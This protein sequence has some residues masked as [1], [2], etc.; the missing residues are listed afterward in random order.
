MTD[1][2]KECCG[3]GEVKPRTP[4]HFHFCNGY[5][6][7]RCKSCWREWE[8]EYFWANR[9]KKRAAKKRQWANSDKAAEVRRA[10]EWK[11]AN[12]DKVRASDFRRNQRIRTS[13]E[14][15]SKA[16]CRVRKWAQANPEATAAQRARRRARE[17]SAEGEYSR[18]DV[19]AILHLQEHKCFYCFSKLT[20]F[21]VDHWIPLS[22]G[23]S[24]RPENIVVCCDSCNSSKGARL[25][26]EWRPDRFREGQSPR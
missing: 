8:R 11:A 12:P 3:C 13:P 21:D 10:T 5:P 15:R 17:M 2:T 23:G 22:R 24:N 4:E 14:L 20:R 6:R 26:W 18:Q 7:P 19:H 9:E 16:T 1:V 25:P